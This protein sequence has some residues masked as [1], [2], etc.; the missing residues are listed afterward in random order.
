MQKFYNCVKW[1][2]W[3]LNIGLLTSVAHSFHAFTA[4]RE[5]KAGEMV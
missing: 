3:D 1:P 4:D 5:L 2:S